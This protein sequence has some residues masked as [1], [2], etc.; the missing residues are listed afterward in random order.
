MKIRKGI[1]KTATAIREYIEELFTMSMLPI[2]YEP[3][4]YMTKKQEKEL[5]E[6]LKKAQQDMSL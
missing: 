6:K 1:V 3:Y 2:I 5:L 4:G